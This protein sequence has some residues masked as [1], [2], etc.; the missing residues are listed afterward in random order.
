MSRERIYIYIICLIDIRLVSVL[1]G[2]FREQYACRLIDKDKT[3]G[4]ESAADDIG[5]PVNAGYDPCDNGESREQAADRQKYDTE[6]AVADALTELHHRYGHYR[7][8]EHRRRRRIRC[9]EHALDENG[10]VVYDEYFEEQI[11]GCYQHKKHAQSYDVAVDLKNAFPRYELY[12]AEDSE[13]KN[14]EYRYEAEDIGYIIQRHVDS[15]HV[16]ECSVERSESDF[17]IERAYGLNVYETYGC[18]PDQKQYQQANSRCHF[19]FHVYHYLS[20]II[21]ICVC[22]VAFTPETLRLIS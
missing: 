13:R 22:G 11:Y 6:S 14:Y 19:C 17:G 20:Q 8:H 1:S 10:T 3:C 12:Q 21:C 7:E 5:D 18:R 16:V 4:Y 15:C 9:L 2:F